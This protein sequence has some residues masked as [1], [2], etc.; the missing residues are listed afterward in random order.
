[1]EIRQFPYYRILKNGEHRSFLW[2][3]STSYKLYFYV[4]CRYFQGLFKTVQPIE[5]SSVFFELVSQKWGIHSIYFWGS[6]ILRQPFKK[7]YWKF[8]K[9][10]LTKTQFTLLSS[11]VYMRFQKSYSSCL[12]WSI[13]KYQSSDI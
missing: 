13:S 12:P 9:N 2:E 3:I 5:F 7:L 10:Y 4:Y 8:Q 1:M 6:G 11:I